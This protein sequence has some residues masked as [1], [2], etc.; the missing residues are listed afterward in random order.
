MFGFFE[1]IANRMQKAE[2][3][4]YALHVQEQIIKG[5]ITEEQGEEMCKAWMKLNTNFYDE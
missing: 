4:K 1:D 3:K 5:E 2:F